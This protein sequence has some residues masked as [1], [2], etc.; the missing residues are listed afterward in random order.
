MDPKTYTIEE[1]RTFI[2]HTGH[3]REGS[4]FYLI[5]LGAVTEKN[6]EKANETKDE[7]QTKLD[8]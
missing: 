1:I 7:D 2:K 3:V 8:I 5:G 6:I 4:R